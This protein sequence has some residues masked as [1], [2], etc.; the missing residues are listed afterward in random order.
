MTIMAYAVITTDIR[1]LSSKIE[2]LH[3]RHSTPSKYAGRVF[4]ET[5]STYS[6][7]LDHSYNHHFG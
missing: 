7:I 2:H 4:V 6:T 1:T 5:C 3:Q